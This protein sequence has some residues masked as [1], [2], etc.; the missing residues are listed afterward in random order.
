MSEE[1]TVDLKAGHPPATKV[2]GM[3]VVQHKKEGEK[4]EP[5]AMT[6]EEEAEF[7]S[8][9]PPKTD[10]HHQ[11]LLVSGVVTKGDKDFTVQ[12]VKSFHEKPLP[13]HDSRPRPSQI[14]QKIQ[15]PK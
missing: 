10:K 12:A 6:P 13:Q 1:S 8:S 2:G 14:T 5:P 7:G 11:A 3:R 4:N 15:Q 9:S